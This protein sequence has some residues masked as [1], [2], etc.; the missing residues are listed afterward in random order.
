MMDRRLSPANKRVADPSMRESWPGVQY[1]DPEPYAV[2]W[3]LV[4][5]RNAPEGRR[6]RQLLFGETVGVYEMHEGW[7]FVQ[8]TKDNYV[9]YVPKSSLANVPE[10]THRV[11]AAA[12]H[13]YARPDFKSRDLMRLSHGC[14]LHGLAV[15]NGFLQT[16]DGYVPFVHCG[17]VGD[18]QPD[19]LVEAKLFLDTPYLWGGNSRFGIDCSGLVQA[20]FLA[21]GVDCPGDSDLQKAQLGYDLPADVPLERNDLLFWKGHVALVADEGRLIHANA[22]HMAVTY[23]GVDAAINRINAQGDGPVTSRKRVVLP[24]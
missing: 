19:P 10:A 21:C 7:A 18:R 14:L 15:E 12:S 22:H 4:D 20:A 2:H 13:V 6:D 17:D 5:L 24:A 1:V 16:A 9:G 11:T 8:S 23:E 3:P